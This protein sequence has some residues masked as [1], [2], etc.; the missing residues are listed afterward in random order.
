[1]TKDEGK[2]SSCIKKKEEKK[3]RMKREG[4]KKGYSTLGKNPIKL[5]FCTYR[6]CYRFEGNDS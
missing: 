5:F 4:E 1:M 6:F 2:K 3:N